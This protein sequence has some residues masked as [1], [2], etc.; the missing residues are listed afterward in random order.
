MAQDAKPEGGLFLVKLGQ[1]RPQLFLPLVLAEHQIYDLVALFVLV[2]GVS[3][4]AV[5][6]RS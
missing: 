4:V 5:V 1:V 3:Q 2:V 6:L